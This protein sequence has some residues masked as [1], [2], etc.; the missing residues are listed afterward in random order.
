[1][2][3]PLVTLENQHPTLGPDV[4]A[5]KLLQN[6]KPGPIKWLANPKPNQ[7][8]KPNLTKLMPKIRL[9]QLTHIQHYPFR[10]K[11]IYIF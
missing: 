2:L 9:R 4:V 6:P 8:L 11:S 10:W 7:R 1:M 3:R 5:D